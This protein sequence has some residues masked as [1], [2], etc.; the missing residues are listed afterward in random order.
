VIGILFLLSKMSFWDFSILKDTIFW[1][2]SVALVMFF[3][4]NNINSNS[5]FFDIARD[6]VKWT[7]ILEFITN[8]YTFSLPIELI[9]IP[10]LIVVAFTQAFAEVYKERKDYEQ[11][12]KFLKNVL[13]FIGTVIILFSLYKTIVSY[14]QLF[15]VD[16]LKSLL[17]PIVLTVLII[18]F[19]YLLSVGINY[20]NLFLRVRF[21]TNDAHLKKKIKWKIFLRAKLSLSKLLRISKRINKADLYSDDD[22]EHYMINLLG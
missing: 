19:I 11:A 16:N 1:F 8:F 12:N 21:M 5:Y 3:N 2:F 9:L 22:L 18:P 15:T 4:A 13:S 7:I 10:I 6:S 20:E 17:L 14:K